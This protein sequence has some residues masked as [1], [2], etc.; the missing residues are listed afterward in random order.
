V[1]VDAVVTALIAVLTEAGQAPGG[2]D[3]NDD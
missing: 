3:R 2:K 1:P